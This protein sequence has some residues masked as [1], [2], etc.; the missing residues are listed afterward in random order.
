MNRKR[1]LIA[2]IFP[3]V[4]DD[5]QSI[6]W[7]GVADYAQEHDIDLLTFIATS[8]NK[9]ATFDPH[10]DIIRALTQN[11]ALDGLIIY[12]GAFSDHFDTA[13]LTDFCKSLNTCPMVC[14]SQKVEGIPSILI[15][16]EM[17]IRK[18]VKHLIHDHGCKTF[19]FVKGHENHTES[20]A[21]FNAFKTELHA[22]GLNVD[23]SFIFSGHF[24]KDSGME[25]ARKMIGMDRLPDAVLCVNDSTALGVISEFAE[26]RIRV[27][28]DVYVAGFDDVP[29]ARNHVPSLTTISQPLY[30]IGQIASESLLKLVNGDSFQG[31]VFVPTKF[32]PRQSC[33]CIRSHIADSGL[34]TEIT[35]PQSVVDP[36]R[37]R[38]D[39][40]QYCTKLITADN[41]E[42][43]T[44]TAAAWAEELIASLKEDIKDSLG[45]TNPNR[46][47]EKLTFIMVHHI[48]AAGS[49]EVWQKVLTAFSARWRS[50]I[51][52]PESAPVVEEIFNRARMSVS[53]FILR[54]NLSD[55]LAKDDSRALIR[56]IMLSLI[57]AFDIERVKN[58]LKENLPTI[59]IKACHLVL[60]G[61][62]REGVSI[63]MLDIPKTSSL[64]LSFNEGGMIVDTG[65]SIQFPTR[66]ILPDV[67][68]DTKTKKNHLLFPIVFERR[69][70][71]YAIFQRAEDLPHYVYEELR[72]HIG[73][74]LRGH[75]LVNELREMSLRDELTGLYNRRGFTY[76]GNHML[77]QAKRASSPVTLMYGDMNKL[78]IIND[79]YGHA[80]GDFAIAK[81]AE[82]L[83]G[84]IRDQDIIA[85]IGGDEFTI[86]AV[87]MDERDC[88]GIIDRIDRAFR[89]FNAKKVRPY[90]LS[91]SV[92]YSHQSD[93]TALSIGE[94]LENADKMLGKIKR[95]RGR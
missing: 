47:L 28:G 35:G 30:S 54:M 31:D 50:F 75:N 12:T 53:D 82:L 90:E 21:R 88:K 24:I 6:V 71:G 7:P 72:I 94:M 43:E 77:S 45:D 84:S 4:H 86:I 79:T 8:Q 37:S 3:A 40:I 87:D 70:Y 74:A 2:A 66:S 92:G 73:N 63:D 65:R 14:I 68:W 59:G 22:N 25:A 55:E 48:S 60:Y 38:K 17:G 76:L 69:T 26:N 46:F 11:L 83:K 1:P 78:K 49:A 32:I 33:G 56:N 27:P 93:P 9:V 91:I 23:E 42:I 13:E 5:C 18:T 16:N 36:I 89:D 85:R 44:E 34:I 41:S 67:V 95:R 10:Y 29:E 80:E 52:S 62:D 64:V 20:E 58:V 15:D 19:A 57:T 81:T 51:R 61:T 39:F